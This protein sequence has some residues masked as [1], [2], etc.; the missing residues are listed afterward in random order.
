[1][2]PPLLYLAGPYP[3]HREIPLEQIT[4][5]AEHYRAVHYETSDRDTCDAGVRRC[6]AGAKCPIRERVRRGRVRC[7]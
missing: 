6:P 2:T 3:G 4:G 1:M 5:V 7:R